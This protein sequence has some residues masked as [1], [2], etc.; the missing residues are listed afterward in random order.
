MQAKTQ[1]SRCGT[2][3][4]ILRVL[5]PIAL[6]MVSQKEEKW[7]ESMREGTANDADRKI[8]CSDCIAQLSVHAV[9]HLSH[10]F[11][12]KTVKVERAHVHTTKK[13]KI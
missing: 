12:G 11:V 7:P 13:N 2:T 10:M 4:T 3:R 9:M 6:A 5:P 8:D 1:K